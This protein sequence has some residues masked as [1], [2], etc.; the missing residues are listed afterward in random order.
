MSRPLAAFLLLMVMSGCVPQ[1]FTLVTPGAV[2]V[3]SV[4]I[5][6]EAGWN[7]VNPAYVAYLRKGGATWTRD[8]LLLN[9]IIVVPSTAAG[10]PLFKEPKASA[11]YP[12]FRADML[13]HEVA[14][15]VESSLTK[16]AGEGEVLATSSNLRPARYGDAPGIVFD[17]SLSFADAPEQRGVVGAFVIDDQLSFVAYLGAH[18]YYSERDRSRGEAIVASARRIAT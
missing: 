9:R 14:A 5:Q 15:F 4:T 17:I 13:P 3:G 7:E 2:T 8:G 6:V 18:P 12:K 1:A 16:I 10:E 11:A